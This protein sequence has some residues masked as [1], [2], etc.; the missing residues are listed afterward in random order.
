MQN[1]FYMGWASAL[2]RG[3]GWWLV[4]RFVQENRC[5]HQFLAQFQR[6]DRRVPLLYRRVE[7]LARPDR[8]NNGAQ[9]HLK[10]FIT[11]SRGVFYVRL[12]GFLDWLTLK[13]I[14]RSLQGHLPA[15]FFQLVV[16][17]KGLNFTS[18]GASRSFTRLLGS[19]QKRA[20]RLQLI[21]SYSERPAF[22]SLRQYLARLSRYELLPH[23]R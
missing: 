8:Q 15:R 11:E 19:L 14:K 21:Y 5:Y 4:R 22:L 20:H 9:S 18:D 2:Y 3:L 23:K 13:E 12:R 10:I 17:T 16:D 7:G 1:F 6:A